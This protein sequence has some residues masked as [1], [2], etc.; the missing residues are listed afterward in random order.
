MAFNFIFQKNFFHLH[1]VIASIILS[2]YFYML[3]L[4]SVNI[5]F[6]DDYDN[7]LQFYIQ[8]NELDTE[9]FVVFLFSQHNEHR[10][11]FNRLI[12]MSVYGVLGEIDLRIF[13]F[14]G[15]FALV[16]ILGVFLF[17]YKRSQWLPFISIISVF[18]LFQFGTNST[19]F[20]AMASLSNYYV[21]LFA[22][23]SMVFITQKRLTYFGLAIFFACLSVYTQANGLVVLVVG[24]IYL[25]WLRLQS[26]QHNINIKFF[27]WLVFSLL[28]IMLY[29]YG[30]SKHTNHSSF[31]EAVNK[32]SLLIGYFFAFLGSTVYAPLHFLTA[33]RDLSIAIAV[34]FG[35]ILFV[36]FLYLT[37]RKAYKE[38]PIIYLFILF[39][40]GSALMATLG[41][42]HFG[43]VQ[44]LSS[45]YL[46]NSACLLIALSIAFSFIIKRSKIKQV[47]AIVLLFLVFSYS[48]MGYIIH[49]P[50]I[51]GRHKNLVD[52]AQLFYQQKISRKLSHPNTIHASI[53]LQKMSQNYIYS[54][55]L[56]SSSTSKEDTYP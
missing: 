23:L 56:R 5:P 4:Y 46:I 53:L 36:C 38:Q 2:I 48:I 54:P 18:L 40:L 42:Y 9:K 3:W 16:L 14:I 11:L 51:E 35:I 27:I 20:W 12:F 8:W 30:Y 13:I 17:L 32:L 7:I 39:L 25:G 34:I 24:L 19:S 28:I 45:R 22:L 1:W 29:F 47:G 50:T 21:I 10:L 43:L 31:T 44:A 33:N 41:R 6:H 49:M 52:G 26:K 55:K 15:N 37:Y